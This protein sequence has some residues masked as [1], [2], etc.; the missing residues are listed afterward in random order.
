MKNKKLG[1]MNIMLK[2]VL[3]PDIRTLLKAGFMNGD[4]LM[5]IKGIRALRWLEFRD[6][7]DE[8]VELAKDQIKEDKG[9]D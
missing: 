1:G 2:K 3:D 6:R 9:K 7:K 8:L 4:L 5:T